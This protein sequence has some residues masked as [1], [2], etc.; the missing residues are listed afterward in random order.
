MPVAETKKTNVPQPELNRREKLLKWREERRQK[1]QSEPKKKSFVVGHVKHSNDT[2][3]FATKI[4]NSENEV[5]SLMK[6]AQFATT[7]SAKPVTRSSARLAKQVSPH[8]SDE[9][10]NRPIEKVMPKATLSVE[11]KEMMS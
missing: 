4:K 3:L 5:I 8:I 7:K 6:P 10:K 9:Q 11:V 2:S 1:K